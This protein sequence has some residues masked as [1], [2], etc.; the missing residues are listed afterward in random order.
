ML[1][2]FSCFYL[3][4]PHSYTLRRK[5]LFPFLYFR[6]PHLLRMIRFNCPTINSCKVLTSNV[7]HVW[8][9]CLTVNFYKVLAFHVTHVWFDCYFP[10]SNPTKLDTLMGGFSTSICMRS[11]HTFA[12]IIL[13]CLQLYNSLYF[14][15]H[16]SIKYFSP[17]FWRKC[18]IEYLCSQK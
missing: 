3:L 12:S 10:L 4:H 6:F 17:I 15:L 7:T 1:Q 16:F 5:L 9:D 13:T 2:F 18:D 11:R 8:S 14:L